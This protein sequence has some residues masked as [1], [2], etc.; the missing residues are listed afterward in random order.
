MP[1]VT[2][3]YGDGRKL[4]R[5]TTGNS[6]HYVLDENGNVLD[7][8]PGLYAPAAFRRELEGSLALAARVRGTSDDERA[9]LLVDY[10]EQRVIAARA[11]LGAARRH[12]VDS[13]R[14]ATADAGARRERARCCPA[15]DAFPRRLWS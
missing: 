15:Q 7:V 3:D 5:T 6:A 13:R 4:E 10:H 2:I 11:R 9:K 8:L 14:A 1:R 12:A